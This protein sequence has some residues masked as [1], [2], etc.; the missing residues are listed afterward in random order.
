MW[1]DRFERIGGRLMVITIAESGEQKVIAPLEMYKHQ[2]SFPTPN[3][4]V[5]RTS[6][7]D[8]TRISGADY[9]KVFGFESVSDNHDAFL[10]PVADGKIIIYA[11]KLQQAL[12]GPQAAF[13]RQIYAPNGLLDICAPVL[14]AEKFS[15]VP[16]VARD[17]YV[18]SLHKSPLLI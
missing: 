2:F 4:V 6:F 1:L 3:R 16:T 10:I 9:A 13:T 14:D 17:P 5:G 12:I 18:G 8:W 15:I 11:S 7:H